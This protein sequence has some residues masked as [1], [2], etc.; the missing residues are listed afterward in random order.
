MKEPI[1]FLNI[2]DITRTDLITWCK[3]SNTFTGEIS[4]LEANGICDMPL[5][6]NNIVNRANNEVM[7]LGYVLH[8]S[9][10]RYSIEFAL[11]KTHTQAGEFV[12][13]EYTSVGTMP[14]YK[15]KIFND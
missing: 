12:F 8:N 2:I 13:N 6:E 5:Y 4:T 15:L 11:H 3:E 10:T 7:A 9:R 14:T 1:V